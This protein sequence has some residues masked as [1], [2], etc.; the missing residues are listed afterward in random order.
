MIKLKLEILNLEKRIHFLKKLNSIKK[1]VGAKPSNKF[2]KIKHLKPN[3]ITCQM[4]LTK[5][6]ARFFKKI[7][8]F[9]NLEKNQLKLFSEP[10]ID[11]ISATLIY[12]NGILVKRL[13]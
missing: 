10:K 11:G 2:K 12:E 13:I 9:L 6:Y 3:V 4:H 5:G 7:K 8:N 1:I